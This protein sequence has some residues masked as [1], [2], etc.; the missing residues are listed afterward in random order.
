M[1]EMPPVSLNHHGYRSDSRRPGKPPKSDPI[2]L[3]LQQASQIAD[4][5]GSS[6]SSIRDEAGRDDRYKRRY[7]RRDDS[8]PLKL[9]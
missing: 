1:I 4:L 7:R 8:P 9:I 5:R 3:I 6:C 2:D